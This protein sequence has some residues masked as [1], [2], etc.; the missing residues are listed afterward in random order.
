MGEADVVE[1]GVSS[2]QGV[3][4]GQREHGDADPACQVELRG[5]T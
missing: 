1:W 2:N 5:R 4:R 3:H